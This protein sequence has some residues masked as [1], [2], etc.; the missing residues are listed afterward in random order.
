MREN[1]FDYIYK[2]DGKLAIQMLKVHNF[3]NKLIRIVF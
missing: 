1:Y 3:H 2:F